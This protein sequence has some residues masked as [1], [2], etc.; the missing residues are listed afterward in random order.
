MMEERLINSLKTIAMSYYP[1]KIDLKDFGS[2]PSHTIFIN[3]ATKLQVQN[4]SKRIKKRTA[5][6]ENK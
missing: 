2:Y 1:F 3:I 4:L 5:F 6:N